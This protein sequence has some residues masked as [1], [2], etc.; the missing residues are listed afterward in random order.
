[1]D[2]DIANKIYKLM[3]I[4]DR[5]GELERQGIKLTDLLMAVIEMNADIKYGNLK[6]YVYT[7]GVKRT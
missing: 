6:R 2:R 4:A 7:V 1:M 5:L 3:H